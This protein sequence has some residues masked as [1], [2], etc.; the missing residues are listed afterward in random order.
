MKILE[1]KRRI[2]YGW[3]VVFACALINFYLGG[4]FFYG[5]TAFFNP[6]AEEFGWTYAAISL[7][8]SIR[9]FES[10]ILA[11]IMG[12]F[13]DKFGPRRLLLFGMSIVGVAFLLLSRI[14]SLGSFYMAFIVLAL[15]SSAA[16]SVVT[17]TAVARW[18]K[19]KIGRTMG[20]LAAGYGL[21]GMLVPGVVW[22]IAQYSWRQALI[23]LGAGMWVIGIPLSLA[24]KDSPEKYGYLPD[25]DTQASVAVAGTIEERKLTVKEVVKTRNFWLLFFAIAFGGVG[26]A[27][28]LVH[29]IPYLTSLGVSR[30][31]AGFTVIVLT[32]ASIIGRLGF[33]W[34]GDTFSKKRSFATAAV[35]EAVGIFAFSQ[36][37]TM[38]QIVISL[39]ISGIGYGGVIPLRP[40]LQ[41]ELF[42]RKAFGTHQGLLMIAVS[43]GS[44][45]AP[46]FVGW[47]FDT[48]TSYRF[49]WLI[50]AIVS[51]MAIPTVLA[52]K[53]PK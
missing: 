7:A 27:A 35:I 38:W 23:I 53:S 34:L 2:F 22:L 37:H 44:V 24:V 42:G 26:W 12:I 11:P 51:L 14:N 5:F 49:A 48:T 17:M 9:G 52:I 31:T 43:I 29:Q 36:V 39:A 10:G 28:V 4:A 19:K 32:S 15:G 8:F 13:A 18:F 46:V 45:I 21:S 20:I 16:S 33:G 1:S 3:W 25:G 47:V 30:E 6:I 41:T 50:L 40:A